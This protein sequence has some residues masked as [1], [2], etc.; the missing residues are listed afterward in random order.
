MHNPTTGEI[1][2]RGM[3]V[4]VLLY[5][6]WVLRSTGDFNSD[7]KADLLF[8]WIGRPG[9]GRDWSPLRIWLMDGHHLIASVTPDDANVVL[10][11]EWVVAGSADFDDDGHTN[12]LWH[13]RG[14]GELM[15]WRM[16]N[17][18]LTVI[19]PIP[20][21]EVGPSWRPVAVGDFGAG[22]TRGA[23]SVPGAPDII[24]QDQVT[25]QAVVW[26]MNFAWQRTSRT[27]LSLP[28]PSARIVGP[29]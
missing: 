15:F 3:K 8:Q 21:R 1:R 9:A 24:W 13:N 5:G 28:E 23:Q 14:S 4:D 22:S 27:G 2:I 7:G 10:E 6:S 20:T 29:R 25:G 16:V 11:P 17:T 12:L 19:I 18:V 26:H